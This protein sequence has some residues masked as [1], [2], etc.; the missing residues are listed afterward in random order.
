MAASDIL[1]SLTEQNHIIPQKDLDIYFSNDFL[2]P[3]ELPHKFHT[4]GFHYIIQGDAF[5]IANDTSYPAKSG[6]LFISNPDTMRMLRHSKD[7]Y[8]KKPFRYYF[9]SFTPEFLG[10]N[11]NVPSSPGTFNNSY[12]LYSFFNDYLKNVPYLHFSGSSFSSVGELFNK[13][14]LEYREKEKGYA[15]LIR[16]YL[17]QI[18]IMAFRN[19]ETTAKNSGATKNKHIVD[20]VCSYIKENLS[21]H[22]SIQ[23]L[24]DMVYLN[25]D[26]LGRLFRKQTGMT[27]N[28]MLQKTRIEHACTLLLKTNLTITD[29]AYACGF[30]N[31]NFFYS[32]FKKHM[33]VLPSDYRKNY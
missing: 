13:M 7:D 32:T 8:Y 30:T 10:L 9:V 31:M 23:N 24:A 14:H 22:F 1:N 26:Y 6:D 28:S 5:F 29:I 19:V 17:T 12:I 11:L 3:T 20:Y 4:F 33:G 21:T 18:L 15:E 16:N 27:I 2:D 25:P